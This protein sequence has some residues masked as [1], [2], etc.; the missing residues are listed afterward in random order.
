[1]YNVYNTEG[2]APSDFTFA[3][4]FGGNVDSTSG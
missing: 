1:V 3:L 4:K 2:L